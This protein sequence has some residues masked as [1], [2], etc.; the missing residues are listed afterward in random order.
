MTQREADLGLDR[1]RLLHAV[2]DARARALEADLAHGVAEQL[3]VLGHVD[4]V[5]RGGDQFHAELLEHALAHEVERA[6]ERGLAAHGR[7]QRVGSLLLDDPRDRS[8]VDRLDVDGVGHLRVGHDRRG[9][10]VH[11]DDP[12]A[13]LAQRLAGLRARVVELAGLADHDRAGADDQDALDVC[14]LGHVRSASPDHTS[15]RAGTIAPAQHRLDES[16]EQRREVA[17]ARARLRVALEAEG[18][19]VGD[20]DALQR[21]VEQRAV[22]RAHVR[23]AASPRPPRSRGSGSR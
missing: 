3:A 6:V 10:R 20:F 9:I 1:E 7:Q 23:A 2:R 8:P 12:V 18:R 17:R 11:Q 4:G 14:A 19:A 15:L 21:T 22:R 5:A 13:L 16:R